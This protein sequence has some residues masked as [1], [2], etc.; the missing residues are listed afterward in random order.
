MRASP[1]AARVASEV[2]QDLHFALETRGDG[3]PADLQLPDEVLQR[4]EHVAAGDHLQNGVLSA[5]EARSVDPSGMVQRGPE[6]SQVL[7]SC[8]G[9][10][11]SDWNGQASR[12]T[13]AGCPG[14]DPP[15]P[16]MAQMFRQ[17]QS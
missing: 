16:E 13:E 7:V 17:S 14:R 6:S 2:L 15:E 1:A 3:Q 9:T 5:A 4:A 12:L 11:V 8:P 10:C